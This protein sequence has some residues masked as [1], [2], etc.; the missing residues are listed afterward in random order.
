MQFTTNQRI[1]IRKISELIVF[2]M[3]GVLFHQLGPTWRYPRFIQYVLCIAVP[4]TA[5]VVYRAIT[6]TARVQFEIGGPNARPTF[7]A[8]HKLYQ[9]PRTF[10]LLTLVFATLGIAVF[11]AILQSLGVP[12]VLTMIT[13]GFLAIV[14]VMQAVMDRVPRSASILAGVIYS[15]AICGYMIAMNPIP[16]VHAVALL[17]MVTLFGACYGYL[18]GAFIAGLFMGAESLRS[19]WRESAPSETKTET[20]QSPWD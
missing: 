15:V 12:L 7:L 2:G 3:I 9:V 14:A 19:W 16:A 5:F 6:H 20:R 17:L 4:L 18:A 10:G 1:R 13:L 8:K 11:A